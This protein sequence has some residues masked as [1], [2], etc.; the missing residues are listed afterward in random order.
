MLKWLKRLYCAH[1]KAHSIGGHYEKTTVGKITV[2]IMK[3]PD[4]GK[5]WRVYR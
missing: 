2:T 5:E 1:K 4:C 3:C